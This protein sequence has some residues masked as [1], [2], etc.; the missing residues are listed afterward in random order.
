MTETSL[1]PKSAEKEGLSFFE[2]VK[3]IIMDSIDN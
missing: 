1:V 3:K 2:L